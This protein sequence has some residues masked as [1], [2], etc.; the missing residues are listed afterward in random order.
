MLDFFKRLGW[1]GHIINVCQVKGERAESL[2]T[3]THTHTHT[4][5]ETAGT[6]TQTAGTHT[7]TAG[8][9]THRGQSVTLEPRDDLNDIIVH[10]QSGSSLWQQIQTESGEH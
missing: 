8:T 7:Q 4:H 3:Q 1:M 2:Q 9:H 10:H 6:H 5:R